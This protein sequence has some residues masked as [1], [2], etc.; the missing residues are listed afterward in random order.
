MSSVLLSERMLFQQLGH[1]EASHHG[2][3]RR[4]HIAVCAALVHPTGERT[5]ARRRAFADPYSHAQAS[6]PAKDC[7]TCIYIKV[8]TAGAT[9]SPP[10][11]PPTNCPF[12]PHSLHYHTGRCI[13][14]I[15]RN[16]AAD[17]LPPAF[18]LVLHHPLTLSCLPPR[19][20]IRGY[21]FVAF[22][23]T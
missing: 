12:R 22:P 5:N 17:S 10:D 7:M 4:P 13:P 8:K 9:F 15:S 2:S 14:K 21:P 6:W 20:G 23:R 16:V 3:S 19:R 1:F 18:I 11:P